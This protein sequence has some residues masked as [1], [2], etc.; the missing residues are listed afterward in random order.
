VNDLPAG[1][2]E[3]ALGD[4]AEVRLGRQRS[5]KNHSGTHMRPYMRAA[6]V[7][8]DGLRLDDVKSMN[9]TDAE[10][11]TYQLAPGDLLLSEASGSA[12]EVG[13]PA[14]WNGEIE[15]CGFQN[16]LLRV[17]SK[18]PDPRYLLHCFRHQAASGGFAR[19]SRGVGIFHLGRKALAETPLPLPPLEEQRRIAAILDKADELRAKRRAALEQLD[20]LTQAIFLDM[21]GDPVRNPKGWERS[22]LGSLLE[23]IESGKS[24]VCAK[25]PARLGQWGV[26]KLGAVTFGR[27][28]PSENKRLPKDT[29]A[30]ARHEVR[31]GDVLFSRKN[32]A[33]LVGACVYVPDTPAR[34]LLSDLIFR[35]RIADQNRLAPRYLVAALQSPRMKRSVQA[36]ATGAA[37]S[38]PNISKQKLMSVELPVPDHQLQ[39]RFANACDAAEQTRRNVE[40]GMDNAESLFASLQARAFRGEL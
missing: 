26:L 3:V 31:A 34:R 20:T 24:P 13:K 27:F 15:G 11:A 7:G 4:V 10:M 8:W 39:V 14:I 18:G 16:T 9:F 29:Q 23:S 17:R 1:W 33:Q 28:D 40:H 21:F 22:T 25:E 2:T 6:N 36:L 38:M 32:T 30:D 35:L 19:R 5:P 12:R 37:A